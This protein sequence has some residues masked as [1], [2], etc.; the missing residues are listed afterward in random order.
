MYSAHVGSA[1]DVVSQLRDQNGSIKT[2]GMGGLLRY[3]SI[4]RSWTEIRSLEIYYE[5][6]IES[7]VARRRAIQYRFDLLLSIGQLCQ[8]TDLGSVT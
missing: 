5:S 2:T 4:S 6:R 7:D 8:L 3:G 1:H